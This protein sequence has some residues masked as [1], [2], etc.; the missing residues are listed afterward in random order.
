[1][2]ELK[3]CP[4]CGGEPEVLQRPDALNGYFCAISCFCGG[5]SARA[6]QAATSD[7]KQ[8]AY[9]KAKQRW[10]RR[11]AEPNEPLTLE[12]LREMDGE[13]VWI[14]GKDYGGW[15]IFKAGANKQ[16]ARCLDNVNLSYYMSD[17]SKTWFAYRSKKEDKCN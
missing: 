1:M 8:G 16:V 17:Y 4:F 10:N 7:T 3:P 11:P 15:T 5:Y 13:P 9:E 14:D 2:S 12:Q 6:H